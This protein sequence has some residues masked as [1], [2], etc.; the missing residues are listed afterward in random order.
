M[1]RPGSRRRGYGRAVGTRRSA[2]IAALIIVAAGCS[3]GSGDEPKPLPGPPTDPTTDPTDA[4]SPAATEHQPLALA[5]DPHR[6]A[7]SISE[8]LARRLVAG[9][10]MRWSDLGQDGGVVRVR[11]GADAI[12]AAARDPDVLAITPTSE[13][14]PVVQAVRV[15]GVDPLR[16]PARYPLT[17]TA[18]HPVGPVT[19]LAIVGDIML[20]RGVGD[21]HVDNPAAP[22]RPMAARLR[23]ADVTVGNLE[24]TLSDDGVP[25]QP[26]DDS[27]AADPAVVPGLASAGFDL[28]SLAN[29]HTGDYGSH[30][31]RQT[32]RRL[33]RSPIRT[34]GAGVDASAARRPVVI[35]RG[36]VRIGFV[37]FNA[38]GETPRATATRPGVVEVRMAPR[39]GPLSRPDLRRLTDTID[40]LD[41]R[42]DVVIAL[43]HWGD[44]YTNVPVPDQR[45]VGAAMIDAGAD[46]VVGG[47]PHWVQGVQLHRGR[48]IAHSLGNFV[49]DMDTPE[50][51]E[52][53]LLEVTLWGSEVMAARFV[54]Y[55][56]GPDFVPRTAA[57]PRA[58]ATLDR[59]WSASDPPFRS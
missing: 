27:F 16:A 33:D 12:R 13:L 32:L 55:V 54:P 53:V 20:G 2:W 6:P 47:H 52:G 1:R 50:T 26:G 36:G 5:I 41:R 51:E 56:I 40:R 17:T 9:A 15:G 45:R 7:L 48:L 14:R 25:Q 29:N 30:A 43:P 59:L 38:I 10:P 37:A 39:T 4:R 35:D 31:L 49:F 21:A 11:R 19:T 23:S 8:P 28:L 24:S 58:D 3:E 22:L 18:A 42:T 57:G 44:Q 34:V 46:L